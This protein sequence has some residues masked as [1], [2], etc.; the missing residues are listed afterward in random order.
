MTEAEELENIE[1]QIEHL[2]RQIDLHRKRALEILQGRVAT[3][4]GHEFRIT[5]ARTIGGGL[6]MKVFFSGPVLKKD[7]TPH[8]R[9]QESTPLALIEKIERR[10]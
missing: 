2:G 6:S 10:P 7:G 3:V 5:H 9:N 8:S 1:T 4:R